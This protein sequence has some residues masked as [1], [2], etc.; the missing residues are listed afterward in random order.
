MPR[1]AKPHKTFHISVPEEDTEIMEWL[2]K[3][4][5]Q[6][7]SVRQL[8]REAARDVGMVDLFI[9]TPAAREPGVRGLAKQPAKAE[10]AEPTRE[11]RAS[12]TKKTAPKD[13]P[14]RSA[15]QDIEKDTNIAAAREDVDKVKQQME[16][17][18]A[19]KKKTKKHGSKGIRMDASVLEELGI[20]S[21]SP[22]L[23]EN[24]DVSDN[25]TNGKMNLNDL[26]DM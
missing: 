15:A 19:A 26:I 17:R 20:V 13:E 21:S 12:N 3:Q 25:E 24:D 11:K 9:G 23:G 14:Q 5:N 4:Y 18:T 8:I 10:Q 16:K 2:S 22:R 1:K 7:S 6:S